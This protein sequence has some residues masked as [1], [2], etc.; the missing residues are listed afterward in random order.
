MR[1][2]LPKKCRK[3]EC[4]IINLDDENGSGTHWVAYSKRNSEVKYF[5]SFGD[6]KPP[7]ELVKYFGAAAITYNYNRL[8]NF[9]SYRCG[10]F[11][12]KFLIKNA[13]HT[14]R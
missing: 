2:A 5:D 13:S 12:I 8:Q 3:Y 9:N 11:C 10:H 4:G 1:N 14:S 7:I 6:L